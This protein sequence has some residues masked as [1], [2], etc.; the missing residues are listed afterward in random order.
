MWGTLHHNALTHHPSR[1][2]T[3]LDRTI[4]QRVIPCPLPL[5]WLQLELHQNLFLLYYI[6]STHQRPQFLR[7]AHA[8]AG[9][10]R[11]RWRLGLQRRPSLFGYGAMRHQG[12]PR[13]GPGGAAAA[14]TVPAPRQRRRTERR[15]GRRSGTLVTGPHS[16]SSGADVA[17]RWGGATS[18]SSARPLAVARAER[19]ADSDDARLRGRA[20]TAA[21]ADEGALRQQQ[22]PPPQLSGPSPPPPRAQVRLA[23]LEVAHARRVLCSFATAHGDGDG[24]GGG[25]GSTLALAQLG[26]ALRALPVEGPYV[27]AMVHEASVYAAYARSARAMTAQGTQPASG[28]EQEKE[29]EALSVDVEDYLDFV[30]EPG[31]LALATVSFVA[32]TGSPCLR[33]GVHGAPIAAG[34]LSP[35]IAAPAPAFDHHDQNRR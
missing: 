3:I 4:R 19:R 12:A 28:A 23:G 24:D 22:P 21:V 2:S 35:H 8:P 7:L 33:H 10:A 11:G 1:R 26:D 6:H 29:E 13:R 31:G 34:H 25:G 17:A 27:G 30:T 15:T 5:C 9:V 20:G 18:R 32:R 16:S 14:A